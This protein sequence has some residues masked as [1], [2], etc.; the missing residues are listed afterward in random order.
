MLTEVIIFGLGLEGRIEIVMDGPSHEEGGPADLPS[1]WVESV[2]DLTGA[3]PTP[4]TPL[5]VPLK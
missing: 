2:L 4:V 1:E 5:S 3:A